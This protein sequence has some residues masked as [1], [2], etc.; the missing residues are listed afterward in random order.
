MTPGHLRL[1]AIKVAAKFTGR[2]PPGVTYEDAVQDAVVLILELEPQHAER[3]PHVA[4]DAWLV[5]RAHGDLRHRYRKG[6]ERQVAQL[7][8]D[9]T[10]DPITDGRVEDLGLSLDVEAAI[11]ALPEQE[12]RVT[13]LTMQ[14]LKQSQVATLLGVTQ[15]VVSKLYRRAR[16]TLAQLLGDYE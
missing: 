4:Q 6:W 3:A 5:T 2:F 11:N 7:D 13:L 8:A 12:R 14:G 1:L 9:S 16:A 15:P 10:P